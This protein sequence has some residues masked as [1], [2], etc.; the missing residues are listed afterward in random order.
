MKNYF[1]F[2]KQIMTMQ[3]MKDIILNCLPSLLLDTFNDCF[4]KNKY[5]DQRDSYQENSSN[6]HITVVKWG[7]FVD[8]EIS[9]YHNSSKHRIKRNFQ[10]HS[11]Q[12][13]IKSKSVHH[14]S[15]KVSRITK[16]S[17]NT[18]VISETKEVNYHLHH[19]DSITRNRTSYQN[20]F[21][22]ADKDNLN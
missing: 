7:Y 4:A 6:S 17:D 12:R 18:P 19:N 22:Y 15:K 3:S 9:H 14:S 10:E 8:P 2:E 5:L 13:Q 1:E 11:Y 20:L 16:N 21:Y